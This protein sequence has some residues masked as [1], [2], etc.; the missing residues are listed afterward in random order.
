MRSFIV[1]AVLDGS[2]FRC[3]TV[4]ATTPVL[5]KILA[6]TVL[7]QK[8]ETTEVLMVEDGERVEGEWLNP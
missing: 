2:I 7:G 8:H 5:A 6:R 1:Y 4:L 3:M